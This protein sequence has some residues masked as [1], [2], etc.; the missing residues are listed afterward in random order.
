MIHVRR[1]SIQS[2]DSYMH[3]NPTKIG[4]GEEVG[5]A[6]VFNPTDGKI[7]DTVSIPLYYTG[8]TDTAKVVVDDGEETE[9]KLNRDYSIDID[10][11]ME[12]RSIHTIVIR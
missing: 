12:P 8:S 5:V 3:A 9:Y 7:V 11:E 2:W 10:F 4:G 6:V 1:P